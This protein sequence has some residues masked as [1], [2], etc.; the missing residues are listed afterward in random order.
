MFISPESVEPA[1]IL[2][3]ENEALIAEELR[4]RLSRLGMTVI[5]VVDSA[6]LAVHAAAHGHP[7]VVLM[8][9]RLRGERDGID[10]ARE[11]RQ[12]DVPVVYLTAHSD[13]ATL[14]RAKQVA[15][16]GYVLKPFQERDLVVA[17]EMAIHRHSL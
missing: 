10:A 13:R 11:I 6:E 15:P 2:I 12:M 1:R 7:E 5:G 14:E 3:V 4:E 9:I 17:I 16:F 8:D